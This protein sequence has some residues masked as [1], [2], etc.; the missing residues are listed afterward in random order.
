MGVLRAA[1]AAVDPREAKV[2]VDPR[3]GSVQRAVTKLA[4]MARQARA[5]AMDALAD[6]NDYILC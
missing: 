4:V 1:K 2:A 3:V 6:G 5:R